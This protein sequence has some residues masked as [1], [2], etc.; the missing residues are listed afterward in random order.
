MVIY[1]VTSR[2]LCCPDALS[3]LHFTKLSD[4]SMVKILPILYQPHCCLSVVYQVTKT[5][6]DHNKESE[7]AS[8]TAKTA[9]ELEVE[10][11][12][13]VNKKQ[14]YC[15]PEMSDLSWPLLLS[16]MSLHMLVEK[17]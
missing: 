16:Y 12:Y 7:N 2:E 5:N 15:I 9:F 13:F 17:A 8:Q 3:I 6:C 14:H 10:Q 1:T 11:K 4:T